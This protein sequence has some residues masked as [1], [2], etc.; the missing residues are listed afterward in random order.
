MECPACGGLTG[1]VHPYHRRRLAA[2]P[3]AGRGVVVELRS[4]GCGA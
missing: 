2:L 4:E 1:R 3:V